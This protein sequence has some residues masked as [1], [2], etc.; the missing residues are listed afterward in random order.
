V[1]NSQAVIHAMIIFTVTLFIVL[2]LGMAIF[3]C[4]R[5][6]QL[7]YGGRARLAHQWLTREMPGIEQYAK[8][9]AVRDLFLA[10]GCLVFV[11]LLLALPA[12]F[13]IWPGVIA[14][15]AAVHQAITAYAMYKVQKNPRSNPSFKQTISDDG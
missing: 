7:T 5:A 11:G 12:Y 13:T 14:F 2:P 4:W 6:Y 10:I 1:T 8:L 9:F 3:L 15:S